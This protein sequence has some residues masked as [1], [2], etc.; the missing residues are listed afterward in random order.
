MRLCRSRP[1]AFRL[2]RT[3]VSGRFRRPV[4]LSLPPVF[5]QLPHA[6]I[7]SYGLPGVVLRAG[8]TTP[9]QPAVDPADQDAQFKCEVTGEVSLAGIRDPS[10]SFCAFLKTGRFVNLTGRKTGQDNASFLER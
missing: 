3:R 2:S 5:V 7:L 8:R 4:K 1:T 10:F 9:R 6:R